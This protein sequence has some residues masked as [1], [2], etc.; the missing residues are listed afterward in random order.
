[1]KQTITEKEFIGILSHFHYYNIESDDFESYYA[2]LSA[3]K[4]SKQEVFDIFLGANKQVILT[5]QS[6]YSK[7]SIED[8]ISKIV[9]GIDLEL[10]KKLAEIDKNFKSYALRHGISTKN[11]TPTLKQCWSIVKKSNDQINQDL[12]IMSLKDLEKLEKMAILYNAIAENVPDGKTKAIKRVKNEK[13]KIVKSEQE[14]ERIEDFLIGQRLSKLKS[15]S[16][17]RIIANITNVSKFFDTI[18]SEALASNERFSKAEI[19]DML[20]DATTI[21]SRASVEKY[22]AISE[23]LNEYYAFLRSQA[24][25][26]N[27]EKL[28]QATQDLTVKA[29]IKKTPSVV[30]ASATSFKFSIDL[31]QGKKISDIFAEITLSDKPIYRIKEFK[32]LADG[33]PDLR[34]Q[35]IPVA[36]HLN[37]L[38]KSPSDY[39]K[40][41]STVL[42]NMTDNIANNVLMSLGLY[43]QSLSRREKVKLLI[44]N[45]FD[46]N[47]F[48][49]GDNIH[50]LLVSGITAKKNYN[51]VGNIQVLSRYLKNKQEVYEIMKHNFSLFRISES[52]IEDDLKLIEQKSG[53][54]AKK[55][56]ELFNNYINTRKII[57]AGQS[58]EELDLRLPNE[59]TEKVDIT[60]VVEKI[61]LDTI[62]EAEQPIEQTNE[63]TTQQADSMTFDEKL[64]KVYDLLWI[65]ADRIKLIKD[66]HEEKRTLINAKT[67]AMKKD[68]IIEGERRRLIKETVKLLKDVISSPEFNEDSRVLLQQALDKAKED[69]K[70][71]ANMSD[72]DIEYLQFFIDGQYKNENDQDK[73][74]TRGE[75]I[76][77]LKKVVKSSKL[78][79][80]T[81]NASQ[82][83]A[84]ET[85]IE[86]QETSNESFRNNRKET[87][88]TPETADKIAE[89]GLIHLYAE[90]IKTK[91]SLDSAHAALSEIDL[92]PKKPKTEEKVEVVAIEIDE[93]S[94]RN[95]LDYWH[96]RE[97]MKRAEIQRVYGSAL[98]GKGSNFREDKNIN[99]IKLKGELSDIEA[100][101]KEIEELLSARNAQ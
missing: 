93:T 98:K 9:Q 65:L 42:L 11:L 70:S 40:L 87:W 78:I 51:F 35:P 88:G 76:N 50:E 15:S 31:F 21:L 46:I 26:T 3:H 36:T 16:I 28:I 100:K 81:L 13:G 86:E 19:R 75:D 72:E 39:E 37:L 24:Q 43:D 53:G 49:N 4:L 18:T 23:V 69:L 27:D 47:N 59:K 1:M 101:I 55:F 38:K 54:N 33:Y 14:F 34:F 52:T 92:T 61:E 32:E 7:A 99:Y 41:N 95:E 62:Y 56:K 20:D 94:L 67:Y 45:G 48:Y 77:E 73:K 29:F 17:N 12:T 84:L 6:Q 85:A 71:F 8:V 10:Y 5:G 83:K 80:R 82:I 66:P 90:E 64:Y 44:E 96:Q 30:G 97:A 89:D 91:K 25:L 58:T 22:T 2:I 60:S 74:E 57:S 68:F 63:E 79:G